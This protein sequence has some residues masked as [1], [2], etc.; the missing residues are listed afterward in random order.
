MEKILWSSE[1]TRSDINLLSRLY[2]D[3][4]EAI[5]MAFEVKWDE[6]KA[7]KEA[8]KESSKKVFA[9][10]TGKA[11]TVVKHVGDSLSSCL[12]FEPGCYDGIWFIEDGNLVSS[13]IDIDDDRRV[14][15]RAA[16]GEISLITEE[17]FEALTEP[18]AKA[19]EAAL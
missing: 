4:D 19:V 14:V 2:K 13:Q 1:I 5:Q 6:L 15:Y 17:T 3:E 10:V 9:M 16:K 11:G 7:L 8:L 12:E 18:L